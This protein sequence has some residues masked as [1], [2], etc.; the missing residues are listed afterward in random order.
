MGLFQRL[1]LDVRLKKAMPLGVA[2]L[3][4]LRRDSEQMERPRHSVSRNNSAPRPETIGD[5]AH[6]HCLFRECAVPGV[7]GDLRR[8]PGGSAPAERAISGALPS[9]CATATSRSYASQVVKQDAEPL[10][11]QI[12]QSSIAEVANLDTC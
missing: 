3:G 7:S 8:A 11:R 5:P 2:L 9:F 12:T 10:F 6:S 4:K 1:N